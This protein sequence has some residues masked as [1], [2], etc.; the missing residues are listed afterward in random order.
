MG[1][2]QAIRVIAHQGLGRLAALVEHG[3]RDVGG[4]RATVAGCF[5]SSTN[6]G[7]RGFLFGQEGQ[8]RRRA[9]TAGLT[10]PWRLECTTPRPSSRKNALLTRL[11]CPC[12]MSTHHGRLTAQAGFLPRIHRCL[13][14]SV[15]CLYYVKFSS[16]YVKL[17]TKWIPHTTVSA[18]THIWDRCARP[19]R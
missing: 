16:S 12:A 8:A 19:D 4:G 17:S 5:G 7:L 1:R 15:T 10:R 6:H 18:L 3:T 13:R 2:P 14:P 11:T 9:A